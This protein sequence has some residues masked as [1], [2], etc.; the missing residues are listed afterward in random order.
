MVVECSDNGL[1]HQVC[2]IVNIPTSHSIKDAISVISFTLHTARYLLSH[3]AW[4]SSRA[5]MGI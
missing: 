2:R 3:H 4:W 1:Y 5:V